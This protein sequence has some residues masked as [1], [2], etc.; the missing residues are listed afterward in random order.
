MICSQVEINE[1]EYLA[2]RVL[3]YGSLGLD[4]VKSLL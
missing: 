3:I 1:I 4:N 2:H